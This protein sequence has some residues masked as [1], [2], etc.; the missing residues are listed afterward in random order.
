VRSKFRSGLAVLFLA[1][2]CLPS[3]VRGQSVAIA[4]VSGTVTDP[5]GAALANAALIMTETEKGFKRN[6]VS[7]PDGHYLFPNLPVGPYRLEVKAPGF[8]DYIQS[9]II[10][11]VNNNPEFNIAMQ[12]GAV[13]ERVEVNAAAGMV[14]TKETSVSSVIEGQRI[15]DLPL[16]NRQATQLILSLGAAVYADSGDTGSKTFWSATRI[17]V[18]G[19]QGNGTAYLLDGGDNTDAMSNV[20]MPFPFPDA[21]QEFS[22]ETSSVSSRFGTHPGATV[23]VVTKSG[24]NAIHGDLFEYIRNGDLDA[25]NFFAPTHDT[26]RRNQ[27][28]ATVGGPIIKDKLF[29]FG[30]WQGTRN[31]SNPPEI[32]THIPT[33]AMLNG[34]FST[35]AGP[36][37]QSSGKGITLNNP[38]GGQFQGNQIPVSQL[39]PVAVALVT[40]YLPVASAG[41]CG[42]VTYGI[43]QTGDSDEA[44]GRIDFVQSSKH[45]I[46][47]RYYANHWQNPPVFVNNNLLTT[48]SPG[49]F[50]LAQ[51]ATLGDTYTITPN[52]VN[53]FHFSFNRIRDNRGPTD[54]PIN[55]TDLGSS[56]YSAVPN[57]LLISSMT[58]GFT[59]YCGTCAPGHFNFNGFQNA[60]DVDF[61][62]GKHQMSFG[63]NLIRI[64]NNTLSGFDENGAPTFNG[65]F[66]GLGLADFMLGYMSDFQQTN[67]TPDDLRQWVMSVYAQ[68]SWRIAKN[69]TFNYGLRWEPTFA[70]PDKYGRG[71]S[72]NEADFL[73]N[74]HSTLHPSA[75]AGLFF[76]GDPGIPPANWNGSYANFAPRL[77]LVWD[78]KGDGKQTLRF[79]AAI[80]YDST[81]TWF[82]ER[83]TTNPPFGNDIDVASTGTLTNPWAGYAGG[84]P[85]PQ[86]PGHLFFP[87]YGTYINMPINPKPT[88]V[89]QWNATYQRQFARDWVANISYIGNHTTHLWISEER[90]P[91]VYNPAPFCTIAGVNYGSATGP[92][93]GCSTTGNTNQRRLFYEQNPAQGINYAS[94]DTMDDGAVARYQGLLLSTSHRF[95]NHFSSNFNFTDS[96]CLSD[97][98]F[99]AALAGP[100]N[101]QPFNRHADWGPCISDTRYNF[102]ASG[103]AQSWWKGDNVWANRFLSD[104]KLAPILTA[105]SGQ[106]L[107]AILTG[108]DNS[109]T[110]LEEDRPDQ[111]LSNV[112][113]SNPN[114]CKTAPCVQW[115][116]PAA[117]VANPIGTYGNVGRNSIRGPSF[118]NLDMA[119]SRIFKITERY[120]LEFRAEA[121]NLFNHANFVGAFAPSGQPA[122]ASYS[123]LTQSLNSS[124]FGQINGAYD[125]RILQGALKFYF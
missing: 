67:A 86:A 25:R 102:N 80:L 78:P 89:E 88:Y 104:W 45:T 92:A 41:P 74:I 31:R 14:E 124:T 83:E 40:K 32:L 60:D 113:E 17:A 56:M 72:F 2:L 57:F 43:P 105:R 115:L 118:I 70:D 42:N 120:N 3:A 8:K 36:Q 61:I 98:D 34:D 81:E 71:T 12:V 5:S 125:P 114:A 109:R 121:F 27:Y 16:N 76:P 75:P 103:V 77:G 84:N 97:Y 87:S 44:I 51:S 100:V 15:N 65:Q 35:I 6:T 23:N 59:T 68:D 116:N 117:F 53:S 10:L 30:G 73:Q 54:A 90:D 18:A 19:G 22:I 64:Q 96:Y 111:V 26:L 112:Y 29:F 108:T 37:C 58:G 94:V 4:Q 24:S 69:F 85:F 93:G 9:G 13:T 66:T 50:E 7:A 20:N 46:F 122:G 33:E 48:T 82:N 101:S 63:Y 107:S 79:G 95:S 38:L 39:S 28:G 21:L 106:P 11:V 99:G 49:N 119:L 47:G 110:G 123:T 55:W 52:L 1:C 62:H 91:A